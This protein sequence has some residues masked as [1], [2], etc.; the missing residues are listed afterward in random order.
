MSPLSRGTLKSK[1]GGKLSIHFCADWATIE[2]GFRTIIS[3]NK[4]SIHGAVSD[5]CDEYRI[6]HVRTLRLVMAGQSDPLFEPASCWWKHLHLRPKIPHKKIYCKS[7]KNGWKGSHKIVWS[8]FVLMHDD[9]GWRRTVFHDKRHWRILTFTESVACREYTLPRDEK[10]SDPK[11]WIRGNTKIWPVP[12]VTT[13]N[14]Q[15]KYGLEI[16]IEFVNKDNS[17]SWVR[18]WDGLKKLVT[19]L[20]DKKYDDNDPEISEINCEEFALKTKVLASASRT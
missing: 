3:G 4:L 13:R 9:K 7:T 11:G 18:I 19:D 10:L 8:R 14:L 2:T 6:C 15:S 1:G 5:V 20:I 12:E 16:R 17:H